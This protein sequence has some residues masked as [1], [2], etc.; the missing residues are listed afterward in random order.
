MIKHAAVW[1]VFVRFCSAVGTDVMLWME[2]GERGVTAAAAAEVWAKLG[3]G[4]ERWRANW[5][6]RP[7]MEETDMY[8]LGEMD[9]DRE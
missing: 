7:N 3:K 1:I 4:R 9:R 2:T 8:G 5:F 6:R